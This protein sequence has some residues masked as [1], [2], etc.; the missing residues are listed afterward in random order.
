VSTTVRIFKLFWADQDEQQEAWLRA[1]AQQGLHLVKV[2]PF[3]FWTFRRG[4]PA[5][6][7]Y[8]VDFPNASRDPAFRQL[9]QDAGWTLAATTVGWHYWR[10]Q[11]VGG[12]APELFSDTTSK[13]QKFRQRLGMFVASSM[14]V[15]VTF[16]LLD[17][18]ARLS[19]L[20]T[21]FLVAYCAAMTVFLAI[22]PYTIVRL[23][24]RIRELGGS[25]PA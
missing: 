2:N 18:P 25:L 9:M 19:Q 20:S 14:P 7:V 1:M 11:A 12:K 5:D 21:P 16:L 4:E 24:R 8:R 22:M 17:M 3:C 10:T 13:I 6:T 15:F 23:L